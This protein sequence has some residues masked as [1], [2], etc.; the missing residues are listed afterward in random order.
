M[1]SIRVAVKAVIIREG[2]LLVTANIDD[3]GTFYLLPGGGQEAGESLPDALRRECREEVGVDVEVHELVLVRDYISA[4]HEFATFMNDAHQLELFFR[5]SIADDAVPASG[6]I[7]D[8]WQSGVDWLE[9]SRI[10]EYRLYP[11]AFRPLLNAVD[12]VPNVYVGDVN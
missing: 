1:V 11:K 10:G 4:N 12:D 2:R 3:E 6:L 9:L 5:C 7:P 8:S